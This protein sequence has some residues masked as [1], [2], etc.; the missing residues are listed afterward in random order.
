MKKN[1]KLY[2]ISILLLGLCFIQ[3]TDAQDIASIRKAYAEIRQNIANQKQEPHLNN[4][5]NLT[6]QHNVPGIGPQT[7]HYT[8]Y[9]TPYIFNEEGDILPHQLQFVERSYN[10]AAQ[11]Y[12]EEFLFDAAGRPIFTYGREPRVNSE[13]GIYIDTRCYFDDY[14]LL[15]MLATEVEGK[16]SREIYRSSA[17]GQTPYVQKMLKQ[18]HLLWV[19]FAD[20]DSKAI[21]K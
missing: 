8:L 6:L 5:A 4:C 13:E 7:I 12:Y 2:F 14:K 16:E 20:I 21:P 18:A 1:R 15:E 19:L 11:K 10:I 17:E 3:S 9:F